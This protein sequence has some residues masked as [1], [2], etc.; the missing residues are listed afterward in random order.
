MWDLFAMIEKINGGVSTGGEG[1]NETLLFQH[2]AQGHS[3][4]NGPEQEMMPVR[5][6]VPVNHMLFGDL[7]HLIGYHGQGTYERRMMQHDCD[8]NRGFLPTL[9]GQYIY[10]LEEKDSVSRRIIDRALG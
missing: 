4:F 9:L 5:N 8:A 7:C 1:M 6:Y 10:D 3:I 2:F